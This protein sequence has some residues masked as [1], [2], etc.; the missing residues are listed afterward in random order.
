MCVKADVRSSA[1]PGS[2]MAMRLEV[3][4]G[5]CWTDRV[6]EDDACIS[7]ECPVESVPE[8]R[9]ETVGALLRSLV[10][11]RLQDGTDGVLEDEADEAAEEPMELLSSS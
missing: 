7:S 5:G 3:A 11:I 9:R 6:L 10:L 1:F 2:E 8:E 4:T